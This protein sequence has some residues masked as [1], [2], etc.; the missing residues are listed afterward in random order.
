M[1]GDSRGSVLTENMVHLTR[2]NKAFRNI[3]SYLP[4]LSRFYNEQQRDSACR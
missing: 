4:S 1:L 2:Y 3:P